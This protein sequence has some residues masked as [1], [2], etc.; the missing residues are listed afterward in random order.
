MVNMK[1]GFSKV[2]TGEAK[3]EV[4]IGIF[5]IGK[6]VV[7]RGEVKRWLDFLGVVDFQLPDETQVS[8]PALLIALAAKRCYKSFDISLNPNLSKVRSDYAEYLDNVL[9]S[10]HGSV[11]EHSV[12]N[13]AVE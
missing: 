1:D 2:D 7:D 9:K 6:T 5:C 12:Y 11:F 4:D 10:G 3:R 8:D 13:F